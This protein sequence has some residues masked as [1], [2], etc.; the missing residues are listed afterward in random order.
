VSVILEALPALAA[1]A[2]LGLAAATA[3][4]EGGVAIA[5][6]GPQRCG[7]GA[8]TRATFDRLVGAP[9]EDLSGAAR[10]EVVEEGELLR[11]RVVVAH[12]GAE[13][14][15]E[16]RSSDCGALSDAVGLVLAVALDPIGASATVMDAMADPVDPDVD[17]EPPASIPL[18][19]EPI[20][21][22][23][24]PRPVPRRR[25]PPLS[26]SVLVSGGGTRGPLQSFGGVLGGGLGLGIA[27]ARVELA[28]QHHF[29]TTHE[30]PRDERVRADATLTAGRVS[31][32][33]APTVDR[34]SF[35]MLAGIEL[36]AVTARADRLTTST[37]GSSLWAAVVPQFRPSVHATRWLALGL[38][39]QL[40]VALRRARFD[41]DDY[42]E[43]PLVHVDPL[44]FRFGVSIEITALQ[45]KSDRNAPSR[46][47]K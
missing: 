6:E 44:G 22:L 17:V 45:Q 18:A 36:G 27:R 4:G 37:T 13:T 15:R 10:V 5:W 1:I 26:V 41:V 35:P 29:R 20:A 43:T 30:H 33:W 40:A 8:R 28:A 31:A 42:P 38:D 19:I 39:L 34:F 32:G 25:R 16:L 24:A 46:A 47:T 7:D 14:Q 3:A 21:A 11:A 12:A 2:A 9:R 23:A